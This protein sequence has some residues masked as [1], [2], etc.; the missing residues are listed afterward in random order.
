MI[1][2]GRL[3]LEHSTNF[4]NNCFF[5]GKIIIKLKKNPKLKLALELQ[6]KPF[7]MLLKIN[8]S[9]AF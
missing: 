2:H 1:V 9:N 6:A 7:A 3:K 5:R 4:R 8:A